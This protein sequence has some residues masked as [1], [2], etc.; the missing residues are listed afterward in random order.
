MIALARFQLDGYLRSLR[1]LHPLIAVGLI[2]V[3]F[4]FDGPGGPHAADLA[5]GSY[6]DVAAF[7]FP[8]AAWAAR[9]LLDT[10]PDV[11]RDLSALAV[12]GRAAPAG[13]LAAYLVNI[14]LGTAL[15][16]PVV[17]QGVM[18]GVP[19]G[20]T[21]AGIALMLLVAVPAT[22]LGAWTSRAVIASQAVSI[23]VLLGGSAL[24]LVLG[25]GPLS[26]LTI[27]MITWLHA[28]HH[29]AAAFTSVLPGVAAQTLLWSA[30]T[31]AA[32][33]ARGIRR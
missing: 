20:A 4:L 32:Y 1:V 25:L 14:I 29:G 11:Q 5:V 12:G 24:I 17:I 27:P 10:E 8:V 15:L 9:G 18:V 26:W 31:G 21:L 33:T 3:I 23:L 28:A 22:L 2:L 6:G 19:A 7:L 16:L 30:V 13:L